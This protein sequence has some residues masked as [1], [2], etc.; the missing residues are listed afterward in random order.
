MEGD[1]RQ[2][3]GNIQTVGQWVVISKEI[4][5]ERKKRREGRNIVIQFELKNSDRGIRVKQRKGS[6]IEREH[7]TRRGS[8][9]TF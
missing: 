6:W 3:K 7:D 9:A 8:Y 2:K 1:E 5:D 4:N